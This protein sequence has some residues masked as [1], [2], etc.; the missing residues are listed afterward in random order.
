ML[1]IFE[2]VSLIFIYLLNSKENDTVLKL[3]RAL[4]DI[5]ALYI[6]E[7]ILNEFV[8]QQ[9][10]NSIEDIKHNNKAQSHLDTWRKFADNW[11]D[12]DDEVKQLISEADC[13]FAQINTTTPMSSPEK[14]S[15]NLLSANKSAGGDEMSKSIAELSSEIASNEKNIQNNSLISEPAEFSKCIEKLIVSTRTVDKHL[16][17]IQKPNKE[18]VEFEKQDLKLNA[19]KQTLES[20]AVA[21]KTCLIHKRAIMDKSGPEAA[22][23][24]SK[25]I[26]ELMNLH[27]NV[28][29][30]YKEKNAVYLKNYEKWVEFNKDYQSMNAWLDATLSKLEKINSA[31][32][33]LTKLNDVIK[34]FN[35]LTSYRL[36]LER[37][38]LNGHE[39]LVRSSEH[40]TLK[41]DLKLES[42]SSKWK[43]LVSLLTQLREK[44][45]LKNNAA[46]QDENTSNDTVK[47]DKQP[48]TSV[49]T[50]DSIQAQ[51]P[52]QVL[53]KRFNDE[54]E[55]LRK[56]EK[57]IDK[58]KVS[59]VD[60]L[61]M[62][63]YIFEL[64]VNKSRHTTRNRERE[65]N[66][67]ISL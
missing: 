26:A 23:A 4:R 47:S 20:L 22:R 43:S 56:C 12:R 14:K 1:Q 59:P 53:L 30:R 17:N 45:V 61:E 37:A 10:A 38:N 31:D 5:E 67:I 60:E 27:Q 18:F 2:T 33:E 28:V 62:E 48:G 66:Y 46:S 65:R 57:L 7:T 25:S 34:D 15:I 24:M 19:I 3:K 29:N 63:R 35:N 11:K 42:L 16:D 21:L 55:W 58:K 40:D 41:I 39:I 32:S 49:L 6:E 36:L 52:F 51:S 9:G 54:Q 50:T 44:L 8:R 13:F 64:K